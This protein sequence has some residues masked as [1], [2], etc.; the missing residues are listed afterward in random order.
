M[1][2]IEFILETPQ[3]MNGQVAQVISRNPRKPGDL[4]HGAKVGGPLRRAAGSRIQTGTVIDSPEGQRIRGIGNIKDLETD[5]IIKEP[6]TGE[7]QKTQV[8]RPKKRAIP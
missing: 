8:I 5:H 3:F 6:R 1:S 4:A 2:L 7:E